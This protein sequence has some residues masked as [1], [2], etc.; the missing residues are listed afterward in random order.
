MAGGGL[1]VSWRGEGQHRWAQSCRMPGAGAQRVWAGLVSLGRRRQ[2]WTVSSA[3]A[4]PDAGAR[5]RGR[6]VG[7]QPR[8]SPPS[9]RESGE[10]EQRRRSMRGDGSWKG[11]PYVVGAWLP[12]SPPLPTPRGSAWNKERA[13]GVHS[14]RLCWR[15]AN[16][17][18]PFPHLR[19]SYTWS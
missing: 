9:P 3:P 19:G 15:S 8:E 13:D 2:S 4:G 17:N 12:E 11:L 18:G 14:L 10:L 1:Q 16:G 5:V 7:I 6:W